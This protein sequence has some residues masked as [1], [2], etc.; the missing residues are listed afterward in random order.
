[1][2]SDSVSLLGRSVSDEIKSDITFTN[3]NNKSFVITPQLS[4]ASTLNQS[5]SSSCLEN[6]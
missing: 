4:V 5:S 3:E 2:A 6:P 1:M